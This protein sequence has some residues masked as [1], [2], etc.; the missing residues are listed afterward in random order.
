MDLKQMQL[1]PKETFNLYGALI[2]REV[3]LRQRG[4]G[5]FR[6]IG[7][8]EKN[9]ARWA[10]STHPGWVKLG[11][12][13]GSVVLAE[14]RT[15]ADPDQEWHLFQAFLGFLDRHFRADLAAINVQFGE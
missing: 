7:R 15:R 2:E 9:Q 10:H 6:R 5:T 13:M 3:S 11:R 1:V 8:K 14:I 12:G 4:R